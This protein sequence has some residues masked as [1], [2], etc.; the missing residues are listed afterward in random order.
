MCMQKV[1]WLVCTYHTV[2]GSRS[3]Y[4]FI[5]AMHTIN[6]CD[7][8]LLLSKSLHT[9]FSPIATFMIIK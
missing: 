1:L 4:L 7:N 2:C 9:I 5:V 6:E 3:V 8:L